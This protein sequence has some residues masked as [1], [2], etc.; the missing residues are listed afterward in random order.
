MPNATQGF[1]ERRKLSR[2]TQ[3]YQALSQCDQAI[4]RSTRREQLFEPICRAV[5]D[6]GGMKAA[7]VGMLDAAT[8]RVVPVA[9]FGN[10]DEY[11]TAMQITVNPNDAM[12]RGPTGTAIR[13]DRPI[14]CQDVAH[15]PSTVPWRERYA[16]RGWAASAAIPLKCG[17]VT[18]GA[19]CLYADAVNAFDEQVQNLLLQMASNISYA[20]DAFEQLARRRRAQQALL[21]SEARY[22]TLFANGSMPK[23]LIDPV[24]GRIVDVNVRAAEYY[25]WDRATLQSMFITDINTLSPEQLRVELDLVRHEGKSHFDFRHRLRSG[26]LRDVEVFAGTISVAGRELLLSSVHDVSDRHYAEQRTRTLLQ[27]HEFAGTLPEREF[28]TKGLELAE[29]LTQSAIGFLHFVNDD[30]ETLELVTWTAG[31]LRGCTAGYDTHYPIS[32]AG[33]WAD[34][35]RQKQAVMFNDYARYPAKHG[36]PVGHAPLLRLISVPVIEDGRVR[37]M[38]G[39]GNKEQDY[40]EE[41]VNTLRLIGNDWWRAT[42]RARAEAALQQRIEELEAVNKQLSQTQLQ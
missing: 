24:D 10:F 9:D 8:L 38:M 34:C 23:L 42:R 17:G 41:D 2:L 26:E 37:M 20:L 29:G 28:L 15:D 16:L 5:V 30:Q 4:I 11:L 36:L 12:G 21:E 3:V 13:E 14:W 33:I 25:G 18:V 1:L 40:S 6:L 32:Q 27:I 7:W 31:A 39:V 22:S 35:F 19:L